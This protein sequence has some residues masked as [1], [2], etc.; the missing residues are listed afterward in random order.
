MTGSCDRDI[1][2]DSTVV[3]HSSIKNVSRVY[4]QL[5]IKQQNLVL[6]LRI[7]P[8]TH[9]QT[10]FA[11]HDWPLSPNS[12]TTSLR[13]CDLQTSTVLF[14]VFPTVHHGIDLFQATN[15]MHTS[16]IL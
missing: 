7:D 5:C 15:L 13:H 14:D 9:S 6:K 3:G 12:N 10:T 4:E 1:I 16:F 11:Q 2:S 8:L